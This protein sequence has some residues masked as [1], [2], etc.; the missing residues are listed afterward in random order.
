MAVR[1]EI[2][3]PY[4]DGDAAPTEA[5]AAGAL[6]RV[7][8]PDAGKSPI[9]V[10]YAFRVRIGRRT[11][12]YG[13]DNS[14]Y[15]HDEGRHGPDDVVARRQLPAHGLR[16][17]RSRRPRGCREPSVYE[18]FPTASGTAI[19]QRLLPR[20]LD[21]RLP[22]VLRDGILAI[23]HPTWNEQLEDSRA[24]GVFN[25]DFF[26]GDLQGVT[27]EARLPE[28]ARRRRDL[29]DADLQGA[30][31]PSLRHRRLPAGRSRTRR[32]CGVRRAVGG[33]EGARAS[34]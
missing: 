1:L 33:G 27:R 32:R 21:D 19:R 13:D 12:W 9:V 30:L 23:L 22:D 15:R 7:D 4:G 24:T 16:R 18:I 14:A 26:G 29:A 31:E 6:W 3:D 17:A 2:G 34:G 28:V 11:L 5:E 8:V 25:R 20:R 10:N